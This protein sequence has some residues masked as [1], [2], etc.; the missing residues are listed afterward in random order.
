MG[1]LKNLFKFIFIFIFTQVHLAY[2]ACYE[3]DSS[4][5][6]SSGKNVV[7]GRCIKAVKSPYNANAYGWEILRNSMDKS[8]S[9]NS[10]VKYYYT[11][12]KSPAPNKEKYNLISG[13]LNGQRCSVLFNTPGL[14]YKEKNPQG[15]PVSDK[16]SKKNLKDFWASMEDYDSKSERVDRGFVDY[17]I[18]DPSQKMYDGNDDSANPKGKSTCSAVGMCVCPAQHNCTELSSYGNAIIPEPFGNQGNFTR[19]LN[20]QTFKYNLNN[21]LYKKMDNWCYELKPC[22]SSDT[23]PYKFCMDEMDDNDY[24]KIYERKCLYTSEC[25]LPPTSTSYDLDDLPQCEHSFEC[26]SGYCEL[27]PL[28][29]MDRIGDGGTTTQG[30]LK[31]VCMP[32]AICAP[33]C[34]GINQA[35]TDN[36]QMCCSGLLNISGICRTLAD[37][38]ELPE[39]MFIDESNAGSC[40]YKIGFND[41]VN[42]PMCEGAEHW[43]VKQDCVATYEWKV[44][45]NSE[46]SY[47]YCSVNGTR[48]DRISKE[49]CIS[50]SWH[51]SSDYVRMKYIYY[52]RLFEGLQWLWG[53]ANSEGSRDYFGVNT[54]AVK[55]F[56]RFYTLNQNI[57]DRFYELMD[58]VKIKFSESAQGEGAATGVNTIVALSEMYTELSELDKLRSDVYFEVSGIDAVI[59]PESGKLSLQDLINLGTSRLSGADSDSKLSGSNV[60]G[61][62]TKWSNETILGFFKKVNSIKSLNNENS[63]MRYDASQGRRSCDFVRQKIG[64]TNTWC[65]NKRPNPSTPMTCAWDHVYGGVND[66][67]CIKEGWRLD[68]AAGGYHG[69]PGAGGLVDPIYPDSLNSSIIDLK[70]DYFFSKINNALFSESNAAGSKRFRTGTNK[71]SVSSSVLQARM[72]RD[73]SKYASDNYEMET[74]CI[75]AIRPTV[76]GSISLEEAYYIEK[77]TFGNQGLNMDSYYDQY[78]NFTEEEKREKFLE[79][80][81]R[82]LFD[83]FVRFH[84]HDYDFSKKT[85]RFY[86]DM[87]NIGEYNGVIE[88]INGALWLIEFHKINAEMNEKIGECLKARAESL[89]SNLQG[90]GDQLSSAQYQNVVGNLGV[91]FPNCPERGAGGAGGSSGNSS[92]GAGSSNIALNGE[93]LGVSNEIGQAKLKDKKFSGGESNIQLS[94]KGQIG[95]NQAN[96]E[97][98]GG[99]RSGSSTSSANIRASRLKANAKIGEVRKMTLKKKKEPTNFL[100]ELGQKL[101]NFINPASRLKS[102][103]NARY[104]TPKFAS[105]GLPKLDDSKS[106][107]KEKNKQNLKEIKNKNKKEVNFSKRSA[108]EDDNGSNTSGV[109]LSIEDDNENV[110]DLPPVLKNMLKEA[111][112]NAHKYKKE[113][114]DSLFVIISKSYMTSGV[115]RL[116]KPKKKKMSKNLPS[117]KAKKYNGKKKWLNQ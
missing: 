85:Y 45:V 19:V 62:N 51:D 115:N 40:N 63:G 80:G 16:N 5:V 96:V 107:L 93:N 35:L 67:D 41:T 46:R 50:G 60:E 74:A 89:S 56:E 94:E 71:G 12:H 65:D 78:R 108:Q 82:I 102:V 4:S 66:G 106:S 29:V 77:Y 30:N 25:K 87:Q 70:K 47:S 116:L 91:E 24:C 59:N 58:E 32:Y 68:D 31:K 84:F 75:G 2:S 52:T 113:D 97:E 44:H 101:S 61:G 83:F 111:Q 99:Q 6:I 49:Q 28:K 114:G 98:S 11:G 27:L 17:N 92:A 79:F 69:T 34:V 38:F 88:L 104:Q 48:I 73:W 42:E 3:P 36:D 86:Q 22:A 110:E 64:K 13:K 81:S 15:Q 90:E 8:N 26:G 18:W 1:N 117:L 23:S 95:I 72:K 39:E 105:L 54:A 20:P 100:K 9:Q 7:V 43:Q 76:P 103:E 21:Q 37:P 109:S 57:N 112:T 10:F 55:S 14:F 33:T 53:K